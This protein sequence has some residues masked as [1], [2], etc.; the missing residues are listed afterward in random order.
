MRDLADERFILTPEGQ[1][2][3]DLVSRALGS[4]DG[5]PLM[6]AFVKK[7]L[8][9]AIVNGICELPRGVV[10]RPL[11]ELGSL[12]YRLYW[13]KNARLSDEARALAEKIL[14]IGAPVPR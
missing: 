7:G 3:R 12:T 2:H 10:T 8:G 5:W 6:L 14:A 11:R 13:R 4:A 9:V 1:L